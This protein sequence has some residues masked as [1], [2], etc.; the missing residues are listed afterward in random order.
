MIN[1]EH[2]L[3][4][5]VNANP[6][7][8][9]TPEIRAA[10]DTLEDYRSIISRAK[11]LL[12][13]TTIPPI[14]PTIIPPPPPAHTAPGRVEL[15]DEDEDV[16]AFSSGILMATVWDLCIKL[17]IP[18]EQAI[19]LGRDRLVEM[20]HTPDNGQ[21]VINKIITAVDQAFQQTLKEN[22]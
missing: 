21:G 13:I 16:E 12:D 4:A 10:I 11:S 2:S 7:H 18:P 20:I 15:S 9:L 3:R 22:H 17:G 5:W 8:P 14:A 6:G 19:R 1:T